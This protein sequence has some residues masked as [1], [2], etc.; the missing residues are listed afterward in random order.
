[1]SRKPKISGQR[2]ACAVWSWTAVSLSDCYCESVKLTKQ[3]GARVRRIGGESFLGE[4]NQRRI[5]SLAAV[6]RGREQLM[7]FDDAAKILIGYGDRVIEGIEQDGVGR[8]R[9]Y[10]GQGQ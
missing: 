1:M 2:T 9:T 8:F 4:L 3:R 10:A 5:T 6:G 7:A